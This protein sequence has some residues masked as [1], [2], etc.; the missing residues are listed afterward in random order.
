MEWNAFDQ[1]AIDEETDS[2]YRK[3]S[4]IFCCYTKL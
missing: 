3:D 4:V 2:E 1:R